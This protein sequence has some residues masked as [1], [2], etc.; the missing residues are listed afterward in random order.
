MKNSVEMILLGIDGGATKI[1][2][3][4]VAWNDAGSFF[5]VSAPE[6]ESYSSQSGFDPDFNPVDLPTQLKEAAQNKVR[7]TSKEIS[8]G[9]AIINTIANIVGTVFGKFGG[10]TLLI[11]I[12]FPGIKTHDKRG[13]SAIANGPRMPEFLN[14]LELKLSDNGVK[15]ADPVGDLGSDADFCGVGENN[16]PDGLFREC[17]NAYYIGAGTGVADVLKL[18]GKLVTFDSARSWIAKT[19]E[20]RSDDGQSF[21]RLISADGIQFQYSKRAGIPQADLVADG[22]YQEAILDQALKGE[23][24]ADQIIKNVIDMYSK[25]IWERLSTIYSGYSSQFQFTNPVRKSLETEHPFIGTLLQR[26]VF[27]QRSSSLINKMRASEKYFT[28]LLRN[29]G[30]L[31]KN[32]PTFDDR[33]RNYYLQN[34]MFR[35]DLLFYSN[36]RDAPALGAA[37]DR[38]L[39]YN[40]SAN[41]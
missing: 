6:K 7:L 38:Y 34:E 21:E 3:L 33:A 23:L 35:K 31:V 2:V 32:D 1:S 22:I 28:R 19:W 29:I 4:P 11:G 27:G 41:D 20:F 25:L 15:L 9:E 10:K 13:I 14:N 16:S 26:I 8:Q 36:L 37:I 5:P 40:R 24:P 12:G 39:T 18:K 17:E 30:S